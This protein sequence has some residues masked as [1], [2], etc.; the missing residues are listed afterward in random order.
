MIYVNLRRPMC[1]R[2]KPEIRLLN[3]I[4]PEAGMKPRGIFTDF[5]PAA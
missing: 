4:L 5:R 2:F 3:A 1:R